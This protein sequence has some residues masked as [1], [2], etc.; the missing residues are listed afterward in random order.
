MSR[1]AAIPHRQV[2]MTNLSLDRLR[3]R[4][5]RGN[6][7]SV[8]AAA[9]SFFGTTV[10]WYDYFLYGT[11]AALVFPRVFFNELSNHIALMVSMATFAA[12]FVLRPLGAAVFGHFGDRLGRKRMLVITLLGMGVSTAAIG[13]IPSQDQI[14]LWAGVLLIVCRVIQ[15]LAVGGEWGGAV[16]MSVEHAPSGK[17]GLYGSTT[18]A[19]VPAG[20]LLSGGAVGL[21]SQ[22]PD[23]QFF[24]WGWRIPFLLSLVLMAIGMYIRIAVEEPPVF[25]KIERFDATA[26]RP[27]VELLQNDLRKVVLLAILQ[28]ASNVGLFLIT[29][30][31]LTYITDTLHMPRSVATTAVIAAAAVDLVMQPVFGTLSDRF[32]RFKIYTAGVVFLAAYAFPFFVLLNTRNQALIVLALALGLGAGH[33]STASLHGVI[34]AEQFPTRYRYT[35]SSI[36]FQTAGIISSAPTPLVAAALVSHFGNP[37][38]VAWYVIAAAVVSLIAVRLLEE[39][40]NRSIEEPCVEERAARSESDQLKSPDPAVI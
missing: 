24:S 17:R 1:I 10:E 20:V 3:P 32:G 2:F 30:Y 19:G 29:V 14:G 21:V 8:R 6:S 7:A 18:Q 35:G 5:G 39:T 23:T 27:V 9:S 28:S 13:A 34:Y 22:L 25:R 33:A 12:A 16:L 11:A 31:S 38:L 15:G 40:F 37:Y 26:E 4:S 36:A